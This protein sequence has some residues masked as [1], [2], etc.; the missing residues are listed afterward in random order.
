LLPDRE[1]PHRLAGAS[2]PRP[3]ELV[4]MGSTPEGAK[5]RTDAEF[6]I[7]DFF[8]IDERGWMRIEGL[9]LLAR[10]SF[11]VREDSIRGQAQ[12]GVIH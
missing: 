9:D 8:E 11:S 1:L 7:Y 3:Q 10:Q 6:S 2:R 12:P 5:A 4:A